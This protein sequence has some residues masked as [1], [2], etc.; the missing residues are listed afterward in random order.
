MPLIKVK[1][2]IINVTNVNSIY[3]HETNRL[4]I[5]YDVVIKYDNN[6][7]VYIE[8][9]TKEEGIETIDNIFELLKQT[10][11]NLK[12]QYKNIELLAWQTEIPTP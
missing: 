10:R 11:S 3:I 5:M 9:D 7:Q 2:T 6:S 1:N 4:G 8:V 12:Y